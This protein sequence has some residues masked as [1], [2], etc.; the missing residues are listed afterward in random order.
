MIR[1]VKTLL[2]KWDPAAAPNKQSVIAMLPSSAK[3]QLNPSS[4]LAGWA[5]L[6]LFPQNPANSLFLTLN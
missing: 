1:V 6:A 5:E 2:A 4:S 3:P